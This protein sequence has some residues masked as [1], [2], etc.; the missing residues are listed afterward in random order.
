[1]IRLIGKTALCMVLISGVV[2]PGCKS[3]SGKPDSGEV[4]PRP[5][6]DITI[7]WYLDGDNNLESNVLADLNEA[8]TVDLR[9][10]NIKIIVLADRIGG[11]SAVDDNWTD[12]RAYELGFDEK[13]YNLILSDSTRRISIPELGIEADDRTECNMGDPATL[14]AFIRFCR[15]NYP[16]EMTMLVMSDHG[17]GW[18]RTSSAGSNPRHAAL[19]LR[20]I[21]IDETS[22]GDSLSIREFSDAIADATDGQKIDL[23]LF[24]ACIMGMVEVGYEI[25]NN[26]RY[27]VASTENVPLSGFPYRQILSHMGSLDNAAPRPVAELCARDYYNSYT[28]GDSVDNPGGMYSVTVSAVDL[29]YM[30]QI[31]AELNTL[32][33]Y[34]IGEGTYPERAQVQE[35]GDEKENI[36]IGDYCRLLSLSGRSGYSNLNTIQDLLR[37]SVIAHYEDPFYSVHT[38][39]SVFFPDTLTDVTDYAASNLSFVSAAPQWAEL[40]GISAR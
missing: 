16:S 17:G 28:T 29:S 26:V 7:M 18:R 20:D 11:Y 30:E 36:D 32:A 27:M 38:G 1:M 14:S 10:K 39:L 25:R 4:A 21:S 24:D 40:V 9:D 5:V 15:E 33:S 31:A 8:E 23:V 12:T 19:T 22:R 34:I 13:G 3:E 37:S 6:S 35:Y 2:F